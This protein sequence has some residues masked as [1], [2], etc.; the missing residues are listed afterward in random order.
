MEVE[1]EKIGVIKNII[2]TST[3]LYLFSILIREA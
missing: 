1:I 2:P 3:H